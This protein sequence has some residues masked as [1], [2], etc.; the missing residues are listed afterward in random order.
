VDVKAAL[1]PPRYLGTWLNQLLGYVL[2]DW[3]DI[4]RLDAV[5]VYLGWQALL[6]HES[7]TGLLA[8]STRG[9]TPTVADLRADF[10]PQIQADVDNEF[11][12]RMFNRYPPPLDR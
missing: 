2:L 11:T 12:A 5:A 3:H 9:P 4:F 1:D 6:V 7:V 8:A 10:R